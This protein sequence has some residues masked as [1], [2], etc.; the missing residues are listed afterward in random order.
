MTTAELNR[1]IARLERNIFKAS[2]QATDIG[3]ID[4]FYKYI[5]ETAKPEFL[6]LYHADNKAEYMNFKSFKIMF[7]LNLRHQFVKPHSFGLHIVLPSE[8]TN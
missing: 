3:Y 5:E 8:I 7:R 6:R 2:K 4:D 1:D